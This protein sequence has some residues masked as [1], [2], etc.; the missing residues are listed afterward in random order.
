MAKRYAGLKQ[1]RAS[2]A[3]QRSGVHFQPFEDFALLKW[4]WCWRN[5]DKTDPELTSKW[6]AAVA[7]NVVLRRNADSMKSRYKT[8]VK[9]KGGLDCAMALIHPKMPKDEMWYRF[10]TPKTEQKDQKTPKL[11]C[12]LC[13]NKK[14]L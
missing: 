7:K 4:D 5:M 9:E 8:V 14:H 2:A 3:E 6:E 11:R 13:N 10:S 12:Y 1:E